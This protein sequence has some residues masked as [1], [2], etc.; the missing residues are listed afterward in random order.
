VLV[1]PLQAPSGESTVTAHF[2]V[3]SW[4]PVLSTEREPLPTSCPVHFSQVFPTDQAVLRF[5]DPR[6]AYV[7]GTL[8]APL[9]SSLLLHPCLS[10]FSKHSNASGI[11]VAVPGL[12]AAQQAGTP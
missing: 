6:E 10:S 11:D 1:H 4:L 5:A 3:S 9:V 12:G 8:A 2:L 7:L